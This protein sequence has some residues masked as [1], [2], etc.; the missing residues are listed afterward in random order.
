MFQIYR[1]LVRWNLRFLRPKRNS[2]GEDFCARVKE[3][4]YAGAT[5]GHYGEAGDF[6]R[7]LR[8]ELRL[9][10]SALV[11]NKHMVPFLKDCRMKPEVENILY[12]IQEVS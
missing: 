12:F 6:R 3:S 2:Y 11:L 7:V 5:V 1:C 10:Y 4:T 9:N 8:V